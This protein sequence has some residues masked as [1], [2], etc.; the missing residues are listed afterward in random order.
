MILK[1]MNEKL[2]ALGTNTE[3]AKGARY[4]LFRGGEAED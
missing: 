4:F 1:A 3:L 2:A